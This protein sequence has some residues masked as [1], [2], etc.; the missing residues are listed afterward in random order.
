M[1]G[2]FEQL[3]GL[4]DLPTYRIWRSEPLDDSFDLT[5]GLNFY[6]P[7]GS[8]ELDAALQFWFP[9]S[10]TSQGRRRD[11][12]IAF[13][14][15]EKVSCS[16]ESSPSVTFD[17]GALNT[18][19]AGT[20]LHPPE[21]A[22]DQTPSFSTDVTYGPID[23]Y[24]YHPPE[25]PLT[26]ADVVNAT[27]PTFQQDDAFRGYGLPD[28]DASQQ[29]RLSYSCLARPWSSSQH[30]NFPTA[31]NF[32]AQLI[33]RSRA[34]AFEHLYNQGMLERPRRSKRAPAIRGGY[35]CEH[36]N[37]TRT[38]DRACDLRHHA[39]MH[40]ASCDRPVVCVVCTKR[41]LWPKDLSRHMR[42][43]GHYGLQSLASGQSIHYRDPWPSIAVGH[44]AFVPRTLL[45]V[46]IPSPT[47]WAAITTLL[48]LLFVFG[49]AYTGGIGRL[50]KVRAIFIKETLN[51][52]KMWSQA[53]LLSSIQ[54]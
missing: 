29:S 30:W 9:L 24:T 53:I 51:V 19:D 45:L 35:T 10:Q 7:K 15:E 39:R 18:I 52:D 1:A 40:I 37:C 32:D 13:L 27:P 21:L 14:N 22:S 26:Y 28:K 33:A 8:A 16:S 17:L 46:F 41:F 3:A 2:Q 6:P 54:S 48:L 23:D 20:S 12:V 34:A 25:M 49:V 11:A 50:L 4:D 5:A 38:F 36:D 31:P 44:Q 43:K 47:L 42:Q